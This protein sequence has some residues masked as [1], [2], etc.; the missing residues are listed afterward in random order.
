M[1][2]SAFVTMVLDEVGAAYTRAQVLDVVNDVQNEILGEDCL[3]TRVRPDPFLTTVDGATTY[4]YVATSYIHNSTENTSGALVG[5]VRAVREIYSYNNSV[6]IFDYQTLDPASEKPNQVEFTQTKDRVTARFDCIDSIA[7]SSSDCTI[8]LYATNNPG[9]TTTVWRCLCYL[10]PNQLTAESVALS[11]PA[12]FQRTLLF[13]GVLKHLERREYGQNQFA[14][15]EYDMYR[16]KFRRKYNAQASS[17][18]KV[19]PFRVV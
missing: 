1:T 15:S 13:M 5:D 4:S 14:L 12:D 7:P 11:V 10:W 6:S 16:K 19:A 18:L 2:T 17:D 9:V 8:K 3:L